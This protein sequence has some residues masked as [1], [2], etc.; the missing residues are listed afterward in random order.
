ME[1]IGLDTRWIVLGT[2]GRHVSLGRASD[3]SPQEIEQA[4]TALLQQGLS[5]WL[6]VMSGDYFGK[7]SP[8]LMM[9]RPLGTPKQPFSEAV[10]WFLAKRKGTLSAVA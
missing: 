6:A 8:S 2:D 7:T 10:G 5:G 3:P 4:E 1:K 9:V